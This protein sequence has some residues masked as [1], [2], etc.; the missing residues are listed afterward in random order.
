M[1][2]LIITGHLGADAMK[3]ENENSVN[4]SFTVAETE[5]YRDKNGEKQTRTTWF[6]CSWFR[7]PDQLAILPYL[8]KGTKV[9]VMGRVG[10]REYDRKDGGKGFSLTVNVSSLELLSLPTDQVKEEPQGHPRQ[11]QAIPPNP[12]ATQDDDLPF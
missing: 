11:Q 2:Q 5:T 8:K 9:A 6:S 1:N 7:K 4:L 10:Y 3:F 12:A